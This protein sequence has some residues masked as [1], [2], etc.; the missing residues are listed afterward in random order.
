MSTAIKLC[1]AA[2]IVAAVTA[3]MAYLGMVTS[4]QYYLTVDECLADAQALV[5]QRVRVNGT[6]AVDSLAIGQNRDSATFE[7]CGRHRNLL[8]SCVAA[9]PDNLAEKIDVVV[10]GHL[11]EA[12]ILQSDKVITRCASKYSTEPRSEFASRDRDSPGRRQ[13]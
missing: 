13:R 5:K 7:L 2:S 3:C 12:G 1:I 11:D 9:L 6:I 8:V 4:W 10:E